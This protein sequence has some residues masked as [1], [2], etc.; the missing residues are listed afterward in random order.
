MLE[1]L[2]GL[3]TMIRELSVKQR[4]S[5]EVFANLQTINCE[6]IEFCNHVKDMKA[7]ID[8][9]VEEKRQVFVLFKKN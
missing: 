1:E 6:K 8:N 9:K 7:Q 4:R 2:R 3:G 5:L